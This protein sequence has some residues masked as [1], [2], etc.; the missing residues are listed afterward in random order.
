MPDPGQIYEAILQ[1]TGEDA[2]EVIDRVV[3]TQLAG[4]AEGEDA[5]RSRQLLMLVK[6]LIAFKLEQLE[7]CL[8]HAEGSAEG[9]SARILAELHEL[10]RA[11]SEL[12]ERIGWPHWNRGFAQ[13][14]QARL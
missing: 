14:G 9:A 4:A 1:E 5:V 13:R 2:L 11:A 12:A 6:H 10:R 7:F 8:S 3:R